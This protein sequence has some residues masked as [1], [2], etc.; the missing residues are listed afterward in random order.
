MN[1]SKQL[2]L[3]TRKM[4]NT[5]QEWPE[6]NS[7]DNYMYSKTLNIKLHSNLLNYKSHKMFKNSFHPPKQLINLATLK[8]R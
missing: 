2:F 8:Q 4:F 3:S 7:Q 1:I 5:A 6:N